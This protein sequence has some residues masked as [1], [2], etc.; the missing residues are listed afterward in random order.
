MLGGVLQT[1]HFGSDSR[2]VTSV[3]GP[4]LAAKCSRAHSYAVQGADI[5]G[6]IYRLIFALELDTARPEPRL[7]ADAKAP[8]LPIRLHVSFASA[9]CRLFGVS[10]SRMH[11]VFYW[12]A[13]GARNAENEARRHNP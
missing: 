12:D 2:Q 1:V 6:N 10:F 13:A 9:K 5:A 3:M 7:R 8:V 11:R 4:N